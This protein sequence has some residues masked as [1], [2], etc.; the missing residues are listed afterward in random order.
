MS[1]DHHHCLHRYRIYHKHWPV[2]VVVV[3]RVE[4]NIPRNIL[5]LTLR[6]I[7][8][9]YFCRIDSNLTKSLVDKY[10][11]NQFPI[12][13]LREYPRISFTLFKFNIK[14][15]LEYEKKKFTLVKQSGSTYL[16]SIP[17]SLW[18]SYDHC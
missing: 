5:Q 7:L 3:L 12:I 17:F 4:L 13:S 2:F 6:V 16:H 15:H 11:P 18:I 14:R 1:I 9:Q 8:L 10:R